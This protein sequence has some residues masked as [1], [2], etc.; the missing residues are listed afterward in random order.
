MMNEPS[1][2]AGRGLL[3]ADVVGTVFA[4]VAGGLG[5]VS[6]SLAK[7]VL[8]PVSFALGASGIVA[9]IWSYAL[10]V[11]RS[12]T[13]EIAVS[14]LYTVAGDVAPPRVKRTLRWSLWAQIAVAFGAM[15]LGFVRTEPRDFNWAA[16]AVVVPL[17][18]LGLNG[19]WVARHGRFSPR[20]LTPRPR[21]RATQKPDSTAEMEQT[22]PHG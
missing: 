6:A 8:T 13:C 18:G 14:Q 9:F 7:T 21:R 4:T 3:G 20:I 12:R 22:S 1:G 17:F 2:V 16:S 5:L 15:I 19:V 11:G 10:A